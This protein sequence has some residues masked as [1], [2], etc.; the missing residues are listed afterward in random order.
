MRFFLV[1]LSL[2]SVADDRP[3]QSK[4]SHRETK[5]MWAVPAPSVLQGAIVVVQH[6][7]AHSEK[8]ELAQSSARSLTPADLLR[9]R[10]VSSYSVLIVFFLL[11]SIGSCSRSSHPPLVPF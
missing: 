8:A 11:S 10:V 3:I 1:T 2:C 6:V 7:V 9:F 4:L 5:D